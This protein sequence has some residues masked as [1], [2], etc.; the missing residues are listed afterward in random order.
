VTGKAATERAVAELKSEATEG[1]EARTQLRA[2]HKCA[3]DLARDLEGARAQIKSMEKHSQVFT[4]VYC[5][6]HRVPVGLLVRC[7]KLFS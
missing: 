1:Y 4:E 6:G 5:R 2:A 3:E 7:V